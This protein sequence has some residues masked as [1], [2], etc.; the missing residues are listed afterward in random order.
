MIQI[1]SGSIDPNCDYLFQDIAKEDQYLL[2]LV[3]T[4][5]AQ[6]YFDHDVQEKIKHEKHSK[7]DKK[8]E[9]LKRKFFDHA[10]L[11]VKSKHKR[12]RIDPLCH[13]SVSQVHEE[14]NNEKKKEKKNKKNGLLLPSASLTRAANIEELQKRLQ[15]KINELQGKNSFM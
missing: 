6:I 3:D 15:E 13:K 1:K 2:Q 4:I 12:A 11:S 14:L 10:E 5:P 7:M 9:N 8:A